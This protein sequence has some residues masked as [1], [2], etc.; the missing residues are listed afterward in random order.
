MSRSPGPRARALAGPVLAVLVLLLVVGA[1]APASA[2]A[3]LVATDP[4][5][6]DV[7]DRVPDVVT[8]TF[9]ESVTL[10]ADA[11]Q[12]FDAAG[13]PVESDSTS[14]G[15]EITTDL[16]D[17]LDDGTYVVVWRAVSAD[18]HP[19]AGSLS[20][21]IGAPSPEVA[22]PKVPASDGGGDQ[23]RRVLSVVQGLGYAGL[24]SAAGLV[25]FL[26]R[27]AAG[28]RLDDRVRVRLDRV[29]WAAVGLALLAQVCALPLSGAYQQGL[30]LSRLGESAAVDP[31]V[32]GDDLV[33]LALQA[34]GLLVAMLTLRR[35]PA[36]AV[37]A[38]ALAALSPALVGHSRAIEPVWLMIVTDVLHLAAGATWLG[39]LVGL[40][41][42]LPSLGGR[43]RDAALVLSRFSTLAA[44]VLGL[45]A[46]TGLLM[47]WRILEGW[48]PLVETTY[49]RPLLVKVGLAAAVGVIAGYNRLRLLPTATAAGGG[50]VGHDERRGAVRRVATAVRIEAALLVVLLGVTGFLTSQ[51]PRETPSI[52]TP[53]ASRVEAGVLVPGESKVLATL[54][55]GTRGPTTITVQVQDAA[56]EPVDGFAEP[57]VS[58]A[59]ADGALDLGRQPVVPSAAGTFTVETVIPSPGTWVVQVA[60]RRSEFDNPVT[61]VTFEV[62]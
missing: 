38:A 56:S 25:L 18:G 7:L 2:H 1:A 43:G 19:I 36:V 42:A 49:G 17:R 41:L 45:L 55:P 40:A 59:S 15:T 6:G 3:T 30:P 22:A 21:S 47:A 39:G 37:A 11:V 53:V 51:S 9:D 27:T 58:I 8:F 31:A 50:G 29:R 54:S 33:V 61:T 52:R 20:F 10:P 4:A 57:E 60:L 16:P 35:R 14:S 5:E 28:V 46:V 48:A 12:A 23:A 32:I 62:T 13:D 34:A 24:L 26:A 44:A